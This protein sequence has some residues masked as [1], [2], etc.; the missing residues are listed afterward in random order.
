MTSL[1]NYSRLFCSVVLV[2]LLLSPT[3]QAQ[4][5]GGYQRPPEVIAKLI[6]AP[7]TPSVSIDSKAEWMLLMQRPGYP[8]IEEVAAPEL[9]IAGS[10][11]NP[12]TNGRSRQTHMT[13]L[14][15]R[16]VTTGEE[17]S[18]SGMPAKPQVANVS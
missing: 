15:M 14:R 2:I 18:F 17:F 10:R 8:S 4:D 6:D 9:R 1:K 11:I 3:V 7:S 16:S 5:N 12:A 13:G